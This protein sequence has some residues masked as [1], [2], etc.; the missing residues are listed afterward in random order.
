MNLTHSPLLNGESVK[1][2]TTTYI[3]LCFVYCHHAI[4]YSRRERER[5]AY[6]AFDN[7]DSAKQVLVVADLISRASGSRVF[8]LEEDM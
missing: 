6:Y 4:L 5:E 2:L 3:A 7:C 1:G 8:V